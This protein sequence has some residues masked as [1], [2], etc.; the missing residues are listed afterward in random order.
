MTRFSSSYYS[1]KSCYI[2]VRGGMLLLC[3][4]TGLSECGFNKLDVFLLFSVIPLLKE[5][6]GI[7]MQRTPPLLENILPQCYQR[8]SS[9]TSKPLGCVVLPHCQGL[10]P[11]GVG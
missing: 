7:L 8:V 2:L 11:G 3:C 5:S 10:Q 9:K 6:V 4:R 1:D